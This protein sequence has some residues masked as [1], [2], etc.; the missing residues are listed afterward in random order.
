MNKETL[1]AVLRSHFYYFI[2]RAFRELNPGREFLPNWHIQAIAYALTQVYLGKTTRLLITVPP[3]HLKSISTTIAF[4]AWLLG[5]DPRLRIVCV[6]YSLNLALQHAAATRQIMQSPW[7][8]EAFPKTVLDPKQLTQEWLHTTQ[9]GYRYT[10][11]VTGSLTGHG[12]DIIILDDVLKAEEALSD[13]IRERT[14][15]WVSNTAMTRLNDQK[16]GRV[17]CIQQRL[18]EDDVIGYLNAKGMWEHLNLQVIAEEGQ[19]IP[20]D[21][22]K[23]HRRE[24][25]DLLHPA[26]QPLEVL[27]QLKAEIGSYNFAAQ[28]QQTPVPL[29]DGFVKW[30]WFKSYGDSYPYPGEVIDSWDCASSVAEHADYT[31]RIRAWVCPQGI[32]LLDCYRAR[33]KYPDLRPIVVYAGRSADVVLVEAMNAGYA[34][35]QELEHS[36]TIP[37]VPV[38]PRL[39]KK[40]RMMQETPVIEQGKVFLPTAAPWLKDFRHELLYFPNGKHDDMVDAFSQLLW[41]VRITGYGPPMGKVYAY[42][43]TEDDIV[44]DPPPEPKEHRSRASAAEAHRVLTAILE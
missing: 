2:Q 39:G 21:D 38:R 18:H 26:A 35:V 31:V 22:G 9:G 34:L 5:R 10:C 1:N 12:A 20:I 33:L 13:T 36:S 27:D 44:G 41:Y 15:Q 11:S 8:K 6:S 40:E 19:T 42:A 32:Y 37:L 28:Y 43:I 17:I 4:V 7:Y 23:V 24:P 3:R 30:E 16:T 29:G 25:G 14:N